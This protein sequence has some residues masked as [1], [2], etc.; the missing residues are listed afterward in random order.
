MDGEDHLQLRTS[1]TIQASPK[2]INKVNYIH[3]LVY[4]AVLVF[5]T[6]CPFK[7]KAEEEAG[8]ARSGGGGS[9]AGSN[10][11]TCSTQLVDTGQKGTVAGTIR[12]SYSDAKVAPTNAYPA[13]AFVDQTNFVLKFSYWNGSAFS[14]EVIA[15]DGA[16]TF[17][18]LAFT[19]DSKPFVVWTSGTSLKAAVRSAAITSSSGTWTAGILDNTGVA[20][21]AVEVA[22]NP[23][24]QIMVS[25]LSDTAVA[26]RAKFAYCDTGCASP[27]D[28]RL[29]GTNPWVENANIVAAQT[30][31]GAGWCKSSSSLYYPMVTYAIAGA[32]RVAVCQN[33]TLSNC[34]NGSNWTR[35]NVVATGNA[36]SKL[37]LD[38]TVTGDVPKVA[39]WNGTN[40]VTYKMGTTACTAAP[41]AF[42]ASANLGNYG[43]QWITFLKDPMNSYFHLVANSGATST[44]YLNNSNTDPTLGWNA[45]GTIDSS[46]VPAATGGGAAVDATTT[47]V[48]ASYGVNAANYDIKLGRVTDYTVASNAATVTRY[49]PDLT[50]MLQL[51]TAGS[52]ISNI[53]IAKNANGVPG[54]VY[55]DFS[56]G[57]ATTGRLKFAQRS[58]SGASATW[59]SYSLPGVTGPQFPSV[60]YDH[61]S[62]PWIGYFDASVNRFYLATNSSSDASGT[63]TSYEF[64]SVPSGA[65]GALPRANNTAVAMFYSSGV[66][67]PV[68]VVTDNNAT[69]LGVK[70]AILNNTTRAWT[71]VQTIDSL[72]TNG[73]AHLR[74]H[75][76]ANYGVA[77]AFQDLTATQVKYAAMSTWNTWTSTFAFSGIN[78]G[79]GVGVFVR[80]SGAPA[81]SYYDQTNNA[82]YLSTCS[83][84]LASCATAGWTSTTVE[85]L[86]GVSGLTAAS[87]QLLATGVHYDANGYNHLLYIRGAANDGNMILANNKT[88]SYVAHTAA[89]GRS[90]G[91][92]LLA[93]A[94][95]YGI[96]GFG[97]S[98]MFS[99]ANNMVTVAHQGPG[100]WLYATSCTY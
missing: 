89:S 38:P 45:V 62:R 32:V 47:G 22:V 60:A 39:T 99:T 85:S 21:R 56:P 10:S 16:A 92:N 66:A 7:K 81:V 74:A 29:M 75:F 91:V 97:L 42:S 67:H 5:A 52:Q 76:D 40:L 20:P 78:R 30:G 24:D 44:V 68:L 8:P 49:V 19:S 94:L 61:N 14:T 84:T 34:L 70:A 35:A 12:G 36:I 63:W 77:I 1:Q 18:R 93:P 72:S 15:G 64:P 59:Q 96:N 4:C 33:A 53:A 83:G 54:I 43:S 6:G 82:V 98:S 87:G 50:G 25:Y 11:P 31:T 27:N 37:L 41:A 13:T 69:S 79:Q 90:A 48:Y 9:S 65:P 100:N 2:C 3:I 71:T 58:G 88:G 51:S 95:N 80:T 73:A 46:A 55:V 57:T 17:V 28:F 26:G 23:L 86:A